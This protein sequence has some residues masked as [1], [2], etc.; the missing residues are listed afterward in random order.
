MDDLGITLCED[1]GHAHDA[2]CRV[3]CEICDVLYPP[4]RLVSG[5]CE[6]CWRERGGSI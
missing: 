3:P 2:R 1:K 4:G 6:E 5:I